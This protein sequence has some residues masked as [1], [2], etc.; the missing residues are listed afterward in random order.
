MKGMSQ[1]QFARRIDEMRKQL[2]DL[3]RKER[4]GYEYQKIWRRGYVVREHKVRGHHM[5]IASRKGR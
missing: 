5:M 2:V 4:E 1:K 3:L